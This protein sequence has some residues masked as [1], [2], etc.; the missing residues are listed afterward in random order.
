MSCNF[1]KLG[2]DMK[3]GEI[4]KSNPPLIEKII[5]EEKEMNP[6]KVLQR[7]L[8]Y[9]PKDEKERV[10]R[11]AYLLKTLT[12]TATLLMI[13]LLHNHG[14]S[15][16]KIKKVF[17]IVEKEKQKNRRLTVLAFL[18]KVCKKQGFEETEKMIEEAA[19][20]LI[21]NYKQVVQ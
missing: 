11:T 14:G 10:I 3:S 12:I 19:E 17:R 18:K 7:V 2:L 4:D 5:P 13:M 6:I 15:F 16:E 8:N 20:E 1:K 21:K 9:V